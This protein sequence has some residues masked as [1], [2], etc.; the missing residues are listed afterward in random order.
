MT[1]LEARITKLE[2]QLKELDENTSQFC[3]SLLQHMDEAK[4]SQDDL[5]RSFTVGRRYFFQT[6]TYSYIGIVSSETR[7]HVVL[8]EAAIVMLRE[9]LFDVIDK[10]DADMLRP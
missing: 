1:D 4:R 2:C 6:H 3:Q 10:I 8:D 9:S 5:S 7:T